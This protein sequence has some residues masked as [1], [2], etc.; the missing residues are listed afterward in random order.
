MTIDNQENLIINI[1]GK[2]Q[3]I[4]R[5]QIENVFSAPKTT[6]ANYERDNV[7]EKSISSL[8]DSALN[9]VIKGGKLNEY[10]K[11]QHYNKYKITPINFILANNIPFCEANVIKYISRWKDKNGIEDLEKAKE[12]IDILIKNEQK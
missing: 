1:G 8:S 11:P 2:T 4:T 10:I 12:Y 3:C 6:C 7:E 5:K 9:Q